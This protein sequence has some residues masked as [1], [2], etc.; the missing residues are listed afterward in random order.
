LLTITPERSRRVAFATGQAM[1]VSELVVVH[2]DV[3]DIETIDDLAG[4]EVYVLRN[5]SYVEHLRALNERLVSA[6]KAPVRITQADSKLL[7]EDILEMV[8]AGVVPISVIDDYKGK[9][10]AKVL[11]D[12]RVLEDVAVKRDTTVGWAVRKDNPLLRD[13]L[14]KY[15]KSVKRGTLLGNILFKRYYENPRWIRNPLADSERSKFRKVVDLFSRYADTYGF[16]VLATTAQAYQESKLDH[17]TR[18][19]RGAV[20]IMQLLPST[21]ADPNVGIADISGLEDNIHA[22][23][24]YLA[25]LRD[26][27]FSD[28]AISDEDRLA[29]SWAAYNAGPAN[30]SKMRR[31]AK[32]MGL[33][34][35]VWFGNVELAASRIVG[36][37]T[38]RYV[39]NIFKYYVAYSL[40]RERLLPD[41]VAQVGSRPLPADAPSARFAEAASR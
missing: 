21:A 35:N 20:G 27:Y 2:K 32:A 8:N 4:R 39:R 38:V 29:F 14:K 31:K 22:G 25:F 37:E 34:P 11:P 33:D 12:I 30:V 18:S 16:D 13:S 7:S 19:H 5:S 41:T 23:V 40:A 6:G 10:W 17:D 28:P 36:T 15:A 1:N 24:K 9:L 3:T 26:R